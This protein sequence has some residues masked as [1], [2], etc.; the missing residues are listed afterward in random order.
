MSIKFVAVLAALAAPAFSSIVTTRD[1]SSDPAVSPQI[2]TTPAFRISPAW[3]WLGSGKE[4]PSDVSQDCPCL[5][6]PQCGFQCPEHW[7]DNDCVWKAVFE[8]KN[9]WSGWKSDKY[10]PV[11]TGY[12]SKDTFEQDCKT[13]CEAHEQCNSC[14][15][16]SLEEQAE[17]FIC[18]LYEE[19]I[20]SKT[21]ESDSDADKADSEYFNAS[22]W[23]SKS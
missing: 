16:F 20:D 6:D 7:P 18:A 22:C 3:I 5:T 14:Q 23:S 13:L 21:W 11:T 8:N 10:T 1:D 2:P 12:V 9:D 19:Y 15:A 4:C 17:Q